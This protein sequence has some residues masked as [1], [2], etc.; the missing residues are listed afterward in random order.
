MPAVPDRVEGSLHLH[1][2]VPVT[3]QHTFIG[4]GLT[5]CQD[6]LTNVGTANASQREWCKGYTGVI[7][8]PHSRDPSPIIPSLSAV[9]NYR[10]LLRDGIE[11]LDSIFFRERLRSQTLTML[12]IILT[13]NLRDAQCEKQTIQKSLLVIFSYL[14]QAYHGKLNY[15][16]VLF[17]CSRK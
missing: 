11:K 6:M 1:S 5:F 16:W 14:W 17:S 8:G 2:G 7:F 15:W 3:D 9:E 10:I 13:R 4:N 12:L